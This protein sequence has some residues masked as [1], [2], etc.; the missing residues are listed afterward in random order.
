MSGYFLLHDGESKVS[1]VTRGGRRAR[2]TFW[3]LKRWVPANPFCWYACMHAVLSR[4]SRC[5]LVFLLFLYFAFGARRG[6]R[7][8]P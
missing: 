2:R 3:G 1:E 7:P 8:S 4:S 6:S 5:T